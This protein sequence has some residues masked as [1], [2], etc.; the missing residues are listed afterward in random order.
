MQ[1]V[2]TTRV[3]TVATDLY[4]FLMAIVWS[5]ATRTGVSTVATVAS[6]GDRDRAVFSDVAAI[7]II[8]ISTTL[9]PEP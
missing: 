8:I 7:I 2:T 3:S 1:L 9:N 5:L 4:L 6:S